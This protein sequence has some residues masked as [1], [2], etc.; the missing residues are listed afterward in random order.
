MGI[1]GTN[2]QGIA[3]S[4]LAQWV[5]KVSELPLPDAEKESLDK[6]IDQIYEKVGECKLQ[7]LSLYIKNITFAI[8]IQLLANS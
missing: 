6:V 1:L 5:N 8:P 4:V 2:S 3:T 7:R